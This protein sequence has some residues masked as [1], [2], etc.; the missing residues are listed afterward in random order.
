[1]YSNKN[2]ITEMRPQQEEFQGIDWKG[3]GR[4]ESP[5]RPRWLRVPE[6]ARMLAVSPRHIYHLIERGELLSVQFG[7]AICIPQDALDQWIADKE[8]E[9]QKKRECYGSTARSR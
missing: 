1:M 2:L 4:T 3:N 6:V 8:A 5:I 7:R 9:A